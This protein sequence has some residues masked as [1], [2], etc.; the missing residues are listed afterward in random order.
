MKQACSFLLMMLVF[1]YGI[2]F[3]SGMIL[4]PRLMPVK[5]Y[6]RLK[7]GNERYVDS[8]SALFESSCYQISGQSAKF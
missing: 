2:K 4:L 5:F 8:M 1:N 3:L 6:L 7:Y